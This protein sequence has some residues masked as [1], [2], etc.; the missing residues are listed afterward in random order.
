MAKK[1]RVFSAPGCNTCSQAKR[2]LT[3]KGVDFDYIDV[4]ADGG[5][6][7]EMKTLSR[8]ARSAPVIA[9][10]DKVLLG[11]NKAELDSALSALDGNP[12]GRS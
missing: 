4:T 11:F 12:A 1:V 6:L 7:Q 8:G 2:Y 5:A 10:G 3:E 9:V